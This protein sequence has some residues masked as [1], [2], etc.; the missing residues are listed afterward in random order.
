MPTTVTVLTDGPF[1]VTGEYRL[2]DAQ[3]KVIPA[4]AEP[5]YLC[6]CGASGNKPFCDGTHKKVGFK[7]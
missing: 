5:A 2:V 6:R 7:G 1:T 4:K 3:G